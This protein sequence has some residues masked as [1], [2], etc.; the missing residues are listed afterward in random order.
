MKHITAGTFRAAVLLL[1]MAGLFTLIGPAQAGC[2]TGT[3][4]QGRAELPGD[5]LTM[6]YRSAGRH[7]AAQS[8]L[9]AS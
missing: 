3:P 7:L 1:A 8:V 9:N 4:E 6:V 5:G 2:R